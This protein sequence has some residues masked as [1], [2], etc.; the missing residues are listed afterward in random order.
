MFFLRCRRLGNDM[1]EMFKMIYGIDK[2]NLGKVFCIDED[3]RIRK[4]SLCL[5]IRRHVKLG[6]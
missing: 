4:Y 1:T 3:K 6:Y 2:V 5:K